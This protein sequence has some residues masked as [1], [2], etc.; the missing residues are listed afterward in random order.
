MTPLHSV[1][2]SIRLALAASLH[3]QP[4]SQASESSSPSWVSMVS[5]LGGALIGGGI[6]GLAAR[7]SAGQVRRSA[8]E[9]LEHERVRLFNERFATASELLGRMEPASRLAGVHAMAGLADDWGERRQT[10]IDV[11]CAYLRMPYQPEPAETAPPKKRLS[12][13]ANREVRHTVIR[14]IRDHLQ[15][16]VSG[17]AT[18]WEGCNFD[19]TGTVF[20][21]GSFSGAR[22]TGGTVNF[23]FAAF[24]GDAIAA[25]STD[26]TLV[27]VDFTGAQFNGATV[28]FTHTKFTD[29]EV[30]FSR[31]RFSGGTVHFTHAEF[32]GSAVDFSQA[33]FTGS[34]VTFGLARLTDGEVDFS[35]AE[36][37]GGTV[38]FGP[39][40]FAGSE[41]D[42]S[43][44]RFTGG[45]VDFG[46]VR[47]S[48]SEVDFT[49][50]EFSGGLAFFDADFDG[51]EVDFS[52]AR[53]T[54]GKVSFSP[55]STQ[56]TWSTGAYFA[57][58]DVH[59]NAYFDGAEVDFTGANF[60]GG[61]V[62]LRWPAAWTVPP[63]FDDAVRQ[64]PPT[65]LLL[66]GGTEPPE[67]GAL[68]G[69]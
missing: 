53:F 10:C 39:S 13:Q 4:L 59:L 6:T 34:T 67:P 65:G 3:P 38:D 41:V 43:R 16:A 22:F 50:A 25:R 9:E 61:T 40:F 47:F 66:P 31:A 14:V 63:V 12:W 1:V 69:G 8:Q 28:H 19:F 15:E 48:S 56:H 20:D 24:T 51:G 21:G 27:S 17:S 68:A 23:S 32:D 62:D 44:A 46:G 18:S 29:G 57:G 2:D 64:D 42:F 26:P 33:Q 11:L 37:A 45:T 36:F 54:S 58:G 30:D 60:T 49:A 35:D 55:R 52:G 5:A 7:F